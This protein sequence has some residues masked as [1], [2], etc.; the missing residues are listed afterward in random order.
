MINRMYKIAGGV[1][2]A[3][4]VSPFSAF[5]EDKI[6]ETKDSSCKSLYEAEDNFVS[7]INEYNG[8]IIELD[9]LNEIE[10]EIKEKGKTRSGI[11]D[12][13]IL[14]ERKRLEEKI[15]D[16][17]P[18]LKKTTKGFLKMKEQFPECKCKRVL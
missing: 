4:L 16:L 17:D 10:K 14:K 13:Q 3:Y 12:V 7:A 9:H 8:Y 18:K 6:P 1:L 15:K 11:F 2:L 5:A